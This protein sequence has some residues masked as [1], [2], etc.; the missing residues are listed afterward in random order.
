MYDFR[1]KI[2]PHGRRQL[3]LQI[4]ERDFYSGTPERTKTRCVNGKNHRTIGDWR[5]KPNGKLS[6]RKFTKHSNYW[7]WECLR[8]D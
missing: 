7:I 2:H 6:F 8:S 4:N 5:M 1:F 3:P